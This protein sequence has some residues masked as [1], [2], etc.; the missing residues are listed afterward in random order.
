MQIFLDTAN[1]E[2]IARGVAT[3]VVAGV[4]TN[5]TIISRENKPLV[6]CVRA[7]LDVD[8]TLIVLVEVISDR[9][10]GMVEEARK[11]AAS[12]EN[13]VVKIPM[14]AE[15]LAAVKCLR[16]DGIR[17]TVTLVFSVNQAIAASC[18]GA[19]Y[20]A[21]F[22]GRLDDI[23]ADG[24]RLVR[25]IKALF[26]V[27]NAATGVLAA[28]IRTPQSVADLFA[29]GCDIVTMP[30]KVLHAMFRHPL[31]DAGLRAFMEDWRK[32]PGGENAFAALH[33]KGQLAQCQS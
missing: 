17:T 25:E 9:A 23:N 19:S 18:A 2:E 12:S 7:V 21:P 22:V 20:V 11:L 24:L 8:P 32:V 13:I 29:A 1:R 30:E 15:G 27:Q 26:K 5:P 10:A 31:T 14:T 4:T 28:S 3:G 16:R 33:R 6:E